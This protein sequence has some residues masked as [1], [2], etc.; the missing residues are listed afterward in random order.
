[1]KR[2]KISSELPEKRQ[3]LS[4]VPPIS[5]TTEHKTVYNT[6]T[7]PA[8]TRSRFVTPFKTPIR[9]SQEDPSSTQICVSQSGSS[10]CSSKIGRVRK[11]SVPNKNT[12]EGEKITPRSK[13]VF[14]RFSTP[15][16]I[17]QGN[18]SCPSPMQTFLRVQKLRKEVEEKESLLRK[19]KQYSRARESGEIE[20]LEELVK[21]WRSVSQDV[22]LK[23]LEH[24]RS[25]EPSLTLNSVIER[26]RVNPELVK[27][28]Q[29]NED[30]TE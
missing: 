30:F 17:V 19:F 14:R 24:G 16:K 5:T 15:L 12:L 3:K 2:R 25:N 26:L 1:M 23:L 9:A 18:E 7:R 20:R 28:D 13:T 10:K 8:T 27:F 21:Q 29:E 11:I 22:L 4:P 6:P